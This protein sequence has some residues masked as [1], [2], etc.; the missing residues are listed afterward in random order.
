M[1]F[2]LLGRICK[3]QNLNKLKSFIRQYNKVA[4]AF[5]GGVDSSF[6][7]KVA[8]DAI[9]KDNVIAITLKAAVN[10]EKEVAEAIELAELTGVRHIVIPVDVMSIPGFA[11]NPPDRCYICKTA[12]FE[13]IIEEA[14]NYGINV[15]FDGTNA[16][17]ENDYRPGMKA[18]KE[19]GVIS[20]LKA[21]DLGKKEI[22]KLSMELGIKTWDKPSMACLA[23]RVP[24]NEPITEEKLR[25]VGKAENLLQAIGFIQFRVRC[26]GNIARV[27]IAPEEMVKALDMNVMK[28]I[29]NGLKDLGFH[30]V[31]LDMQGYRTGSLNETLTRV[32]SEE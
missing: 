8:S 5:S 2:K 13:R 15:I 16:D 29:N 20:P 12:I 28:Y 22:R 24:Y 27:E 30:Y 26:H 17:D 10:P 3:L 9:G 11:E 25:M 23:S 18:L 4:I 6:L 19:L 1:I 21:C 31:T 14:G 7:L 32:G